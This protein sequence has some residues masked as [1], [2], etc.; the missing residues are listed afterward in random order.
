ML[1][2]CRRAVVILLVTASLMAQ[3]VQAATGSE[4]NAADGA[5]ANGAADVNATNSTAEAEPPKTDAPPPEEKKTAKS[6]DI[7]KYVITAIILLSILFC[8]FRLIK[9]YWQRNHREKID[10]SSALGLALAYI[11]NEED[12]NPNRIIR[13]GVGTDEENIKQW[14]E[15]IW[16]TYD[17][18]DDGNLDKREIRKFIDQ[19]FQKIGIT[20]EFHDF[21]FDDFFT[22]LDIT[23]SGTVSKAEFRNFLTKVGKQEPDTK[24]QK[25]LRIPQWKVSDDGKALMQAQLS[26]IMDSDEPGSGSGQHGG[27]RGHQAVAIDEDDIK[28][29]LKMDRMDS[30]RKPINDIYQGAGDDEDQEIGINHNINPVTE[31]GFEFQKVNQI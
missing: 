19:T 14:V 1:S 8:I 27:E 11:S 16:E 7:L 24:L 21:D 4:G 20:F 9:D 18:N 26:T 31:G 3:K 12:Q 30:D 13:H 6:S 25:F 15:D 10:I 17:F 22:N 28:F 29:D 23:Q 2:R 5:A